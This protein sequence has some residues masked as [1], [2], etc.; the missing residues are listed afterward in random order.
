MTTLS[1]SPLG[2]SRLM[3]VALASLF[4]LPLAL[5]WLLYFSASWQP[6]TR[7]HHGVLINPARPLNFEQF[8][9]QTVPE[10]TPFPL[11]QLQGRWT[12]LTFASAECTQRCWE[13]LYKMRQVKVLLN[14]NQ[15]RLQKVLLAANPSA[16][17]QLNQLQAA[18]PETWILS[19]EQ[20]PNFT[21][22]FGMATDHVIYLIDPLGNYLM[23]YPSDADPEGLLKD[24]KHL[25]KLSQIG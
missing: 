6:N 24:L 10:A 12:L 2:R 7:T 5:A 23:Y 19:G 15:Q 8:S 9:L 20:L 22:Q 14:K 21:A 11:N 13:N 1:L 25:L 17:Q 18:Y 3:L 16:L 4:I